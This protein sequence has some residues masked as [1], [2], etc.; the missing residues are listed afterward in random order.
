MLA[1]RAPGLT[2]AERSALSALPQDR[3]EIY[4]GM[5]RGNQATMLDFVA[6]STIEVLVKYGGGTRDDF[7]RAT[8]VETPRQSSRLRELAQ[9][10]VDHLRGAGAVHVE[11]CPALLD[12]ARLDQ[13]STEAFYAPDDEGSLTPPEFAE[14]VASATVEEALSLEVKRSSAV[15]IVAFD[16]D[17]EEWRVRRFAEGSW[18]P[19]PSRLDAPIDLL[20]TR[21]P[22]TL[23][24]AWH[25]IDPV[26]LA[27][28]RDDALADWAS[29]E[30]LAG[31]W[32]EATGADSDDPNAPA[33]FFEQV[34]HW[35][36]D[37]VLVVR[38][39]VAS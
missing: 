39:P 22:G 25:R 17:V 35:V 27:I 36:R 34:A 1:R 28:L 6:P 30:P 7:A 29:L 20:G 12:I 11:R 37:G 24:P 2:P 5:L 13:A 18:G 26:I 23:Q 14:A 9:R 8:L 38:K 3:V 31:A 33:H 15:Q 19:P 21:D 32:L 4:S 10:V 16:F